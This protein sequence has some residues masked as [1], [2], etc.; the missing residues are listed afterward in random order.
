MFK[1]KYNNGNIQPLFK[2]VNIP[3]T[4]ELDKYL[5]GFKVL[6]DLG[7][8]S[9]DIRY[10][11]VICKVCKKEFK[12]SVYHIHKIKSCG[13]LPC[14]PSKEL[15]KIIN[16]FKILKDYGYS[17]GSR[18]CL[19]ICKECNR[20]YEVDPNKLKYRNHCGCI[21]KGVIANK[22]SKDFPRLAD[23]YKKMIS[24]CYKKNN[25]DYYLYGK[26]GI[27]VC[28]EWK[29]DRNTFMEWALNNGYNDNLTIDRIN[30]ENGYFPDNCRWSN[31][32]TQAR[33]TNRNVMTMDNAIKMRKEYANF[34]K[35]MAKKFN[36]SKATV[37]NVIKRKSW[38]K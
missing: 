4:Q 2:E 10:A 27:K 7:R 11:L 16:G 9:N 29:N 22:Y 12:T 14:R 32:A 33:N 15:P 17:N 13:C 23:I 26:K 25:K 34:I 37:Y 5:N 21:R 3:I 24:R 6:K 38:M 31:A 28:N 1:L 18:R 19:A 30:N 36:C 35:L 20:E 8:E